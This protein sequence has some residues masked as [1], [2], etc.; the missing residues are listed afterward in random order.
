MVH[1]ALWGSPILILVV[2]SVLALTLWG[3]TRLLSV[4]GP[5]ASVPASALD[6]AEEGGSR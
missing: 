6:R 3:L 5:L 2:D 4:R 1:D